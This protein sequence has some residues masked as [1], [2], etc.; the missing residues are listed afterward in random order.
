MDKKRPL[1]YCYSTGLTSDQ[2]NNNN[3]NMTDK[4]NY[5]K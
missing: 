2:L 4:N 5:K 1:I 3:K